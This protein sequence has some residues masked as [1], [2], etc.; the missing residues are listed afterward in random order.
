M[1]T[2]FLHSAPSLLVWLVV[3]WF[4]GLSVGEY[5]PVTPP[6]HS[7]PHILT[8]LYNPSGWVVGL[9]PIYKA[10]R[11]AWGGCLHLVFRPAASEGFGQ[12]AGA[13]ALTLWVTVEVC[14]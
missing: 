14:D 8:P 5:A 11:A 10:H 13:E 1:A 2:V 6:P 4:T 7:T 3:P 12:A 9:V